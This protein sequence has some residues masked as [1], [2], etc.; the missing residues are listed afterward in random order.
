MHH[1]VPYDDGAS[2]LGFGTP[3]ALK[4]IAKIGIWWKEW[5]WHSRRCS[6]YG[7]TGRQN[8]DGHYR[9]EQCGFHSVVRH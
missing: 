2:K 4:T 1:L 6:R 8:V 3:N 9:N 5:T 7:S